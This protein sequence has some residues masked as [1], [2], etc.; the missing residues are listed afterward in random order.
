R[1]PPTAGRRGRNGDEL[2]RNARDTVQRGSREPLHLHRRRAGRGRLRGGPPAPRRVPPLPGGVRAG[3]GRQEAGGQ[4]LRLRPG[5]GG[6][7]QQGAL[8]AGGGPDRPGGPGGRR[9]LTGPGARRGPL[10]GGDPHMRSAA[11]PLPCPG[12]PSRAFG[13]F[14]RDSPHST[15]MPAIVGIKDAMRPA[16]R[17]SRMVSKGWMGGTPAG[18]HARWSNQFLSGQSGTGKGSYWAPLSSSLRLSV[19]EGAAES[20]VTCRMFRVLK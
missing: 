13:A 19:I 12:G 3:G 17:Y 1:G 16:V 6:P 8:P 11:F 14:F 20:A 4:A 10:T 2:R 7:A 18:R 5:P 9:G 15:Y